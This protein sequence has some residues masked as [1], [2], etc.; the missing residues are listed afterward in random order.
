M[1]DENFSTKLSFC[2]PTMARV[3]PNSAQDVS[4]GNKAIFLSGG[5]ATHSLRL[6]EKAQFSDLSVQWPM[7]YYFLII[8]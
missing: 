6:A 7:R 2:L 4:V 1:R 5:N 8:V 3:A